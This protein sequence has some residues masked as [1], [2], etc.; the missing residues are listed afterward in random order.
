M[1]IGNRLRRARQAAGFASARAAALAFGWSVSTYASH[2]NGQTE[3]PPIEALERYAKA[4]RVPVE[5]IAFGQP[6]RQAS[7]RAFISVPIISW[8]SAGNLD[9]EPFND[10]VAGYVNAALPAG[11]WVALRVEG[12]SMDRISPPDSVIFLNTA[13]RQLV[14]NALYVIADED[15]QATYKRY[16][17]NPD[18]FEPISVSDRHQPIFPNGAISIIGRVR[19]TMLDL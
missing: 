7:E 8:V 11:K 17:P 4:F 10:D 18:R 3:T 16:R 13:E 1:S 9:R 6:Q 5:A 14:P 12:D 15:G 2:E 19:R